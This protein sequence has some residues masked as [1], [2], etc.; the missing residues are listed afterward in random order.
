ML[1]VL[2]I[3]ILLLSAMTYVAQQVLDARASQQKT[4]IALMLAEK[5]AEEY[6]T[7]TGHVVDAG[8]F[9]TQPEGLNA[10]SIEWPEDCDMPIE[11]FVYLTYGKIKGDINRVPELGPLYDQL[12]DAE[13]LSN[14]D[15]DLFYEII[16]GYRNV[17][18]RKFGNPIHYV[19]WNQGAGANANLPEH[20]RPFFVSSG[21]DRQVYPDPANPTASTGSYPQAVKD[22]LISF[23]VT[24]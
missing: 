18:A 23:E 11:R 22:N 21:A 15:D 14:T 9:G 13:L 24:R 5:I 19:A 12:I 16:D 8:G 2:G 3:I 20:N 4:E 10:T 1:V 6:Q 17:K 7:V